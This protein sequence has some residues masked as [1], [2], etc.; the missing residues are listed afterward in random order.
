[1]R[2][3]LFSQFDKASSADLLADEHC[4]YKNSYAQQG[5][6]DYL[7][8]GHAPDYPSEQGG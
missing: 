1:M 5:E 6:G 8:C 4:D 2:T 7:S 3:A